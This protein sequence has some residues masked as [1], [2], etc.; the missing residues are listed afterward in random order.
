MTGKRKCLAVQETISGCAGRNPRRWRGRYRGFAATISSR[1]SDVGRISFTRDA[2]ADYFPIIGKRKGLAVQETIS[3]CA[4]RNPRLRRGRYRGFAA[5]IS[6][7][8]SDVGR[9][10]KHNRTRGARLGSCAPGKFDHQSGR[11]AARGILI[12]NLPSSSEYRLVHLGAVLLVGADA[13]GGDAGV[14]LVGVDEPVAARRGG[15]ADLAAG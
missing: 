1:W 15:T 12:V 3:G 2:R 5:T 13:D 6:S 14:E 7:R 11:P 4:G 10:G 9:G 8:W